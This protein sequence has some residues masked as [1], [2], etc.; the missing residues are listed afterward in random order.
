MK[1]I[2][3]SIFKSTEERIKNPFMGAFVTSWVLFNWKPI[4]FLVFSSKLIEDKIE[5]IQSTFSNI[6]TVFW[7]PL[8]ATIFYILVLPYLNLLIDMLLKYSLLKRNII[9]IDKQKLKIESE[10]QL[11]IEEIKL[12]EAKT[13]FRERSSHNL[14]VENL[15]NK[16]KKLEENLE[17][18]SNQNSKQLDELKRK[19]SIKDVELYDNLT[20]IEEERSSFH[21]EIRKL[22]NL[23][24]QKDEQ[25]KELQFIYNNRGENL[26]SYNINRTM[27]NKGRTIIKDDMGLIEIQEGENTMYYDKKNNKNTVLK[28]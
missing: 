28:N 26:E 7:Y 27:S 22:N 16:I 25:I 13:E 21:Q 9:I 4:L 3:S 5:Y 2:L 1:K 14:L 17:N 20:L 18:I 10:K 19:L 15:Q 23:I 24:F 8:L 11:A 6:N 12:E